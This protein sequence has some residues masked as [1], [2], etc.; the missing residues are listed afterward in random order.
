MAIRQKLADFRGENSQETMASRYGVT[1]QAW[2]KWENG[3]A[4]PDASIMLRLEKDSG[5]PMEE[6]FFDKFNNEKK[7][8]RA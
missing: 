7:L 8:K 4:L 3:K 2:W 6:L 1:Q 5:I